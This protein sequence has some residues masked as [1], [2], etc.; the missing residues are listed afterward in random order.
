MAFDGCT[1]HLGAN[2]V[3]DGSELTTSRPR[4]LDM[5]RF[6]LG[7]ATVVVMLAGMSSAPSS[8]TAQEK[9]P[10]RPVR[11]VV[12]LPP[13]SGPDIRARIVADQLTRMWGRQV[14]VENRPGG[15]GAIGAQAALAATADG[16]T[17]LAA[18]A[19]TFTILPAQANKPSFDVNRDFIPIGLMSNEG[20]VFAVSPKL[21]VSTLAELI[22]R[23]KSDPYKIIIGT[24]PAGSLPHL[25]A[26]LFVS[27]SKAPITVVPSTGGTNEAVREIMGGRVHAVIESQP[28][29]RGALASGEVKPLAIMTAERLPSAP[30]L[31]LALE[32]VPGLTAVGWVALVAPRGTPDAIVAQ[33]SG[34][35]HKALET[36]EVRTRLEQTGTPFRPIF[37]T[38]LARFIESE[39]KLWWPV[40]RE[41]ETK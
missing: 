1:R 4:R 26:R 5:A 36:P 14:V 29:L 34:D 6:F 41:A 38:E 39:Q 22:A 28:G 24:N 25:A 15:G 37:T 18:A 30:D 33:L 8:A 21:G 16:Y 32:T 12:T 7:L 11:I 35:L 2:E 20:M 13:G 31:P 3:V 40:V 9:Y 10:S 17:L 27:L 23:A 19:S